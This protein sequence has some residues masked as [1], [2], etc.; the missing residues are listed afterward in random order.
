M[1]LPYPTKE[2]F[3]KFKKDVSNVKSEV[4]KIIEGLSNDEPSSNTSIE[5]IKA[6]V[7]SGVFTLNMPACI[8]AADNIERDSKIPIGTIYSNGSVLRHYTVN[9]WKTLKND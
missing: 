3:E 6:L 4:D 7:K 1:N 8:R 2:E 5:I 9:G